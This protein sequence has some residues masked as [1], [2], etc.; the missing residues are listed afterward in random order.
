MDLRTRCI[1]DG[2]S[3]LWPEIN[4]AFLRQQGVPV[5]AVPSDPAQAVYLEFLKGVDAITSCE[6]KDFYKFRIALRGV[7]R[8]AASRPE[9][10][11]LHQAFLAWVEF[12][13]EAARALLGRHVS[14][15]PT[16]VIGLYFLHMLDF[17]TGKT[18]ALMDDLAYCDRHITKEHG[19]YPFYLAIK[20]FVHCEDQRFAEAY[21]LGRISVAL[22]PLNIYGVHAV[23]HA[24]HEQERWADLCNFLTTRKADWVGNPGMR[25]HVYWHLAVAYERSGSTAMAIEAFQALCAL[26]QSPF[27]KQDL[28]AVAFLWRLRLKQPADLRFVSEWRQLAA[29]WSGSIGSST[30]Y[31]HKLHAALAFCASSQPF[32]I[33]KLM[34][35]SDGFGIER[36]THEV[37]MEVLE[38]IRLFARRHYGDCAGGLKRC[39][40]R[41]HLLGGSRA[42]REI[43][44]LTAEAAEG[45][46]RALNF[47]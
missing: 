42:Q 40:G 9:L 8:E 25:M 32:L 44:S 12:D 36:A 4:P 15:F 46:S 2:S 39:Q 16:D 24:L 33:D 37:G 34:A 5:S 20:S 19:L 10:I 13:Y 7:D 26:K 14:V 1:T 18:T 43:L 31:F 30:S 27:A 28:D 3:A 35:E 38:A 22:D 47:A 29:L 6:V 17:S 11:F 45:Y 41:W 23:A 21:A